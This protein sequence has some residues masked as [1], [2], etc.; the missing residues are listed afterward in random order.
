MFEKLSQNIQEKIKLTDEEWQLCKTFFTPKKLRKKQFLLHEGDPCKY[1]AFIEKG[2][3]RSYSIDDK[4]SEHILQ[5]ALEGWWITDLYSFYTGEPAS[6]SIDALEDCEVLLITSP[7]YENMM[8]Q[9]PAME[10]YYR[11]LLQNRLIAMQRR[12][13]GNLSYT[14]EQKYQWLTQSFPDIFQRVPQHMVASYLGIT[15]ETLSRIRTRMLH[16]KN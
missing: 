14:A 12:L 1:T 10:R 11:L 9:I 16:K 8:Q 4:G 5:F 2:A 7:D 6:Y 3:M 15:K 13:S